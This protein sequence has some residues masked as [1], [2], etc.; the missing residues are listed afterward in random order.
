[1]RNVLRAA[2]LA[3]LGWLALGVQGPALAGAVA[4]ET[5]KQYM[6]DLGNRAVDTIA[7]QP[8]PAARRGAF[9]AMMLDTLDFDA[10]GT[11]AIGKM[12]RSATPEEKR[13]FKPLFAAYV[14]DVAIQRFGDAQLKS[15]GLGSAAPQPN[16]DVKVFTRLV[17]SDP[18]PMEVHWRVHDSNGQ[19]RITDIEVAGYSLAMHY[20]G[21]FE[22]AG[23]G[24]MSAAINRLRE[25][26]KASTS[27]QT[28]Q[29]AMR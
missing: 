15:F 1:M 13:A 7:K 17:T 8:D 20:R 19:P 22:R 18:A 9:I 6:T 25:L 14:I 10:L 29:Q 21:D 24:T 4:P 28:V 12:G 23:I 5:A 26:T 2:V 27:L 16:G 3:A 11:F